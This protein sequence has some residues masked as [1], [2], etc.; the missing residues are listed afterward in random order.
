MAKEL[1]KNKYSIITPTYQG[2]FKYIRNYLKSFDTYVQD[3]ES[4]QIVFTIC[5]NEMFDFNE[6]IYPYK[7]KL[8][9]FVVIFEDVL[10]FYNIDATPDSLLQKYGRF[11]F[12]TLKKF[13][14]I[15]YTGIRYSLVLDSESMWI[16]KV[17]M[18]EKFIEYYNKP[19]ISYSISR[20]EL[21]NPFV[22]EVINN[23]NLVMNVKNERWFLENFVWFYELRILQDLINEYGSPYEIIQ[24][25]DSATQGKEE[26]PGVFEIILYHQYIYYHKEKYGYDVHC[27]NDDLNNYLGKRLTSKYMQRFYRRF[28]GSNGLAEMAMLFLD[29]DNYNN[30]SKMFAE[31]RFD[32]VRCENS[33]SN[34]W[35]QKKF[36]SLVQPYIF[37]ASQSHYFGLNHYQIIKGPLKKIRHI[38]QDYKRSEEIIPS[39]VSL[40]DDELGVEARRVANNIKKKNPDSI[41]NILS[42]IKL[43]SLRYLNVSESAIE[44]NNYTN[45]DYFVLVYHSNESLGSVLQTLSNNAT[46]V[47]DNIYIVGNGKFPVNYIG[48]DYINIKPYSQE[49]YGEE[50][51]AIM[52]LPIS[53]QGYY[54]EIGEY[55]E[56]KAEFI[57]EVIKDVG[58]SQIELRLWNPKDKKSFYAQYD[59]SINRYSHGHIKNGRGICIAW[60][61]EDEFDYL[62]DE[63][64]VNVMVLNLSKE[65]L[66]KRAIKYADRNMVIGGNLLIKEYGCKNNYCIKVMIDTFST[67]GIFNK[68]MLSE[69]GLLMVRVS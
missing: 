13:Y 66:I 17:N 55:S 50:L 49:K 14:T 64:P 19:F 12:Q 32:I 28:K 60:N 4:I 22:Q 31:R 59:E 15:L 57:S 7:E 3:K 11:S 48:K 18:V 43:L 16:R 39:G 5:A 10:S 24:Y 2:H 26:R 6:I 33:Y 41:I 27:I 62:E 21:R 47:R 34:Y 20:N 9:I 51:Q 69:G 52:N 1:D 46:V 30:F 42:D 8:N 36:I 23:I 45:S 61:E 25:V 68:Y 37:A 67:T 63:R 40:A 29:K 38:Y 56:K 53:D 58:N 65:K 54:F 35:Y 44:K